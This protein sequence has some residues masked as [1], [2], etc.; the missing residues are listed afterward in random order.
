MSSKIELEADNIDDAKAISMIYYQSNAPIAVYN[1]EEKSSLNFPYNVEKVEK[2][3]DTLG[4]EKIKEIFS[5]I[6]KL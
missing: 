3:L 5:T 2:I 4:T 1:S 6:K